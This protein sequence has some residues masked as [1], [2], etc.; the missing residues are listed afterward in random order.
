MTGN[1]SSRNAARASES[2]LQ[3][4][5][6]SYSIK[7]AATE[8]ERQLQHQRGNNSIREAATGESATTSSKIF[9]APGETVTR[10]FSERL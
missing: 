4:E 2:Q 7:E 10:I 8:S 6:G 9:S 1:N 5:R 3:H